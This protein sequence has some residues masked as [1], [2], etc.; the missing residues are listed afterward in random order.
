MQSV[1]WGLAAGAAGV[2]AEAAAAA[3]AEEVEAEGAELKRCPCNP[4]LGHPSGS[5]W[6]HRRRDERQRRP[7]SPRI[8]LHVVYYY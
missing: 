3:E 4:R 1:W 7:R 5:P 2:G 8:V 6:G